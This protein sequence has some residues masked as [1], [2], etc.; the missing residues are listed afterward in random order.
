M[1]GKLRSCTTLLC[2][3]QDRPPLFLFFT[4]DILTHH[5]R[6]VKVL[7]ITLTM[8]PLNPSVPVS[9][10]SMT[11]SQHER[12][13]DPEIGAAKWNSAIVNCVIY[14]FAFP[15]VT[16]QNVFCEEQ[17]LWELKANLLAHSNLE[18]YNFSLQ[19]WW[20]LLIRLAAFSKTYRLQHC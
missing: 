1:E 5:I 9:H 7:L 16:C 12:Y 2:C 14:T 10:D 18:K 11:V 3:M 8:V 4:A 20:S 6:K 17:S 19:V 15:T 13:Q